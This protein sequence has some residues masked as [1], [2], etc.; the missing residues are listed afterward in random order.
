MARAAMRLKCACGIRATFG[1][2]RSFSHASFT[3]AVGLRLA[4][5]SLRRTAD[6]N[7]RNS[8]YVA[9]NNSSRSLASVNAAPDSPFSD[10]RMERRACTLNDGSRRWT[11]YYAEGASEN[12]RSGPRIGK[13]RRPLDRPGISGGSVRGVNG[14]LGSAPIPPDPHGSPAGGLNLSASIGSWSRW[15]VLVVASIRADRMTIVKNSVR[16]PS[17]S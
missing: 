9:L 10:P 16:V 6:A 17:R 1:D 8:P 4:S 2:S 13:V 12:V 15:S 3:S 7:L 5:E 11:A 14:P